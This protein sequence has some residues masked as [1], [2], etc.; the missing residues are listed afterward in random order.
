MRNGGI[1]SRHKENWWGNDGSIYNAVGDYLGAAEIYVGSRPSTF[2]TTRCTR[3]PANIGTARPPGLVGRGRGAKFLYAEM[4]ILNA[5]GV[6]RTRGTNPQ[7][8]VKVS[9]RGTIGE[10]LGNLRWTG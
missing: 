8:V 2:V 6:A 3:V 5:L 7:H 9:S 4:Q 10:Q 1:D